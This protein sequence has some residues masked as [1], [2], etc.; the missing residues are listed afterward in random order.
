MRHCDK[1]AVT[2]NTTNGC[3]LR[4]EYCMASSAMEQASPI[5]IPLR[6]AKR[7]I[8]DAISGFPTGIGASV[9]RFFSPGEPTQRMDIVRECMDYA[10]SLNPQIIT[11]LQTN[12]VFESVEDTEWIAT[13][14]NIVWFSLDGPAEINDRYR[15]DNL[16]HGRTAEIESNLRVVKE[17]T[18]VGV[19]CTVVDETL[20]SQ[21][22]LVNYYSALGVR[23]LA[24]NPVI[25]AICRQDE[26]SVPVTR[27]DIMRFAKGFV[28]AH[29]SARQV[30]VQLSSSLSFNFD[31]QTDV[32]C[33]SCVP[34][35]QL[36]PDGSVSSCD[37]ALYHDT[38]RELRCFLYGS[39]DSANGNI[40]YD[41]EKI[42]FLQRRRLENLPKCQTCDIRRYCAGGCAG[43]VAFQTGNI[44]DIIP[45]YCAATKYLA[46]RLPLGQN[47]ISFTHP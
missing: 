17:R 14:F 10:R 32:A 19:R 42:R 38:K 23:R 1:R 33:R 30:S 44:Y 37:M 36:N 6:F 9:L 29:A 7:G 45:E 12:G 22:E 11:E 39:W 18:D 41:I 20:D 5:V 4:C 28:N 46:S 3:Q 26:G 31:E 43:R 47:L 21:V 13:N 16:G 40:S 34:M 8:S 27:G 15:P 24:F 2:V 35:P 25:R